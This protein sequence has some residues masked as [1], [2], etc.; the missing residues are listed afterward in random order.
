MA[1]TIGQA[2]VAGTTALFTVPPGPCQLSFYASAATTLY[3]GTS[4]TVAASNGYAVSTSPMVIDTF[5]SSKGTT[6]WG[7]NTASTTVPLYYV[8]STAG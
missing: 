3:V 4:N 1:L 8:I 7:L 6:I 5:P 2:P